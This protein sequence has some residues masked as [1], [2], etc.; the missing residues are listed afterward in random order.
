MAG[1][2]TNASLLG[3]RY[4]IVSPIFPT[5]RNISNPD[6]NMLLLIMLRFL[7]R[8]PPMTINNLEMLPIN[9]IIALT[10]ESTVIAEVS[11]TVDNVT[12][13]D[14]QRTKNA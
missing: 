12:R 1:E 2:Y 9:L 7:I 3:S 8:F 4:I 13:P 14:S 6:V 11:C 5:A 10:N